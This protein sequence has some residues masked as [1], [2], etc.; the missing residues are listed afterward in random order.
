MSSIV[1]DEARINQLLDRYADSIYPDRDSFIEKLLSGEKLRFY[2][3]IDPTADY[4]HLGHAMNYR[5]LRDFHE[6]GH[7]VVVL[8]GDFTARIGDPTD[9]EAAR[10][11]LSK[12]EVEENVANYKDQIGKI[13]DFNDSE[14]PVR[15]EFNSQWLSELSFADVVDLASNFTV[16]QM[17]ERDTFEKRLN[18]KKPLYVHE[19]FYPLMQ[20]YDSVAL[21]CD[22]EI[23]GTDQT[24]NML[25][26]RT[27]LKRLKDK[28]KFVLTHPLLENPETGEILMS[29]SEGTGIA[30]S[31]EPAD[32]YAK[33]MAI[34]DAGI[35]LMMRYTTDMS[36][37]DIDSWKEK[38]EAGENPLEAKKV[39]AH[40]ITALYHSQKAAKKAAKS[41][42]N[43]VQESGI[44]DDVDEYKL[45]DGDRL[46][47]V[48]VEAGIVS[49]NSQ[50]RRLVEQG[51][52]TNMETGEKVTD[53]HFSPQQTSVFK[54]GKHRFVK[55]STD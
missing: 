32:M 28:E 24:F 3:G 8:V 2:A 19:F 55:V 13:L 33:V 10:T 47:D 12:E 42:K 7:E 48:V 30:L 14:N 31:D 5:L 39:L 34:P 46:M 53:P 21:E 49:S 6:L 27:L 1:T 45:P 50:F 17:I 38:L 52:I 18:D 11:R 54:I 44:P 40:E 37:E 51:A 15:F 22:V 41:F 43:T 23:G 9:K 26:G 35:I 20:G 25:A 36:M 4:V 16:Q 29:K